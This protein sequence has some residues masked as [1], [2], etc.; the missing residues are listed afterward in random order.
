LTF[1]A[2]L[3][4]DKTLWVGVESNGSW[5]AATAPHTGS[6]PNAPI[7]AGLSIIGQDAALLDG[8]IGPEVSRAEVRTDAGDAVPM[9]VVPLPASLGTDDRFVWALVPGAGERSTVVGYDANGEPIG[10]QSFPV[11]PSTEIGHGVEAGKPW[12]LEVTHDNTG[13]GLSFTY[14]GSGGGGGGGDLG[15][16]VFGPYSAGGRSWSADTGWSTDP[17]EIDGIVTAEA[18][19][20]EYRLVDGAAISAQLFPVP[21]DAFGGGAQAFLLFVPSDVLVNAGDLVASGADGTEIGREYADVSPVPLYPKALEAS[22][23]DAVAAMRSLQLAGAV[24]ARYFYEHD[25]WDGFGPDAASQ[26]SSSLAYNTSPTAIAGEVSIR[27]ADHR[28]L[29]LA[30]RTPNGDVYSACMTDGP[31]GG[32][33]GRNDTSDPGACS[34]GW[35]N[36]P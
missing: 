34:N 5:T 15:D 33:E 26:I 16:K 23:P 10:N 13:W 14:A 8:T 25:S 12:S 6:D 31:G 30:T 21:A 3:E 17:T 28:S 2:Y 9:N 19:R 7:E 32:L 36:A 11:S 29:V 18:A 35:L 24:A 1:V 20:V 4:L 27:V 22:S